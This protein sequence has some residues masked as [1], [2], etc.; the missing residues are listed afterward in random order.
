MK[1]GRY[2]TILVLAGTLMGCR[3]AVP[4]EPAATPSP[5]EAATAFVEMVIHADM[6]RPMVFTSQ[7]EPLH[8]DLA[9]LVWET[10]GKGPSKDAAAPSATLMRAFQQVGD[11]NAV[12]RC[13]SVRNILARNHIAYG[14]RAVS[15]VVKTSLDRPFEAVVQTVS[16]PAVSSDGATAIIAYSQSMGSLDGTGNLY[17]LRRKPDGAWQI[18]AG[19]RLWI[20]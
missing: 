18:V 8:A 16:I 15:K 14:G 4:A 20:A 3:K 9:K 1:V 17:M 7:D 6:G 19:S 12:S 13:P 10:V 11:R 5:C 2:A